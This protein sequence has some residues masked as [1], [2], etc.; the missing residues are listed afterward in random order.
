MYE[1]HGDNHDPP[2]TIVGNGAQGFA[3]DGGAPTQAHLFNPTGMAL[4]ASGALIISDT[5]N[6]RIRQVK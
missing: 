4:G 5:F 2:F 3:G 6:H 1:I